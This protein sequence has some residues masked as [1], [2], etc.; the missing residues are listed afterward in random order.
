MKKYI[1]S[2]IAKQYRKRIP[3]AKNLKVKHIA[4][5]YQYSYFKLLRTYWKSLFLKDRYG[6]ENFDFI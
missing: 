2:K 4:Y 5:M 3:V 6:D 1:I